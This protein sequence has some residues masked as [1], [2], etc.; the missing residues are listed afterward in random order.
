VN[1]VQH[2]IQSPGVLCTRPGLQGYVETTVS[3]VDLDFWPKLWDSLP[4]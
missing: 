4:E 2:E 1:K 3:F